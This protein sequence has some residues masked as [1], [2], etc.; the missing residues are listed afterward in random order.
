MRPLY[1]WMLNREGGENASEDLRRQRTYSLHSE[2]KAKSGAFRELEGGFLGSESTGND[3]WALNP[4]TVDSYDGVSIPLEL[5]SMDGRRVTN[6][7]G[8]RT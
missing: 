1:K 3:T 8:A 4:R 7:S 2:Q 5:G 6:S